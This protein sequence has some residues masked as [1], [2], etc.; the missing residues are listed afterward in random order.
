MPRATKKSATKQSRKRVADS[1]QAPGLF[2][3]R[4]VVST[5]RSRA[6]LKHLKW[7]SVELEQLN[8]LLQRQFIVGRDIMIARVLLKK[9]CVVPQHRHVNEQ[10]TY[11]LEGALKFTID[12]RA[13]V[14]HAGEVLTIPPNMPHAAEALL[15]TVDLDVFNPPRADWINKNDR[16][17]R[18]PAVGLPIQK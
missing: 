16:Y 15:D 3:Q 18:G 13:I 2:S 17:L 12:G 11:I 5:A 4:G 8:P 7:N 9:G 10:V 6:K 14:V 1:K